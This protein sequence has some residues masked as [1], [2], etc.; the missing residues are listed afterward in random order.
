[1]TDALYR[2]IG[3]AFGL[4]AMLMPT[5]GAGQA[6]D[7][8][9]DGSAELPDRYQI[10]VILFAHADFDP[11][12]EQLDISHSM[13]KLAP[14]GAVEK[15]YIDALSLLEMRRQVDAPIVRSA[16][17]QA[18][19]RPFPSDYLALERFS[20]DGRPILEY[21]LLSSDALQLNREFGSISRL[22]AY[23]PLAHGGWIQ[24]GLSEDRAVPFDLRELRASG[25]RGTMR[26]HVSRFLH[27]T[28][29]LSYRPPTGQLQSAISDRAA[30]LGVTALEPIDSGPLYRLSAERRIL[31]GELNYIDHPAFGVL[32]LITLAPESLEPAIDLES[33]NR[34]AA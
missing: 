28:V 15:R 29:D 22:S 25:I 19:L 33:G 3:A 24:D 1:M 16:G 12:E 23:M 20:V 6:R 7:G 18:S 21:E 10:E 27:V 34:P 13:A 8:F 31:R 30:P 5:A 2:Q 11:T 17:E 4:I 26:L 9:V 32:V 14:S